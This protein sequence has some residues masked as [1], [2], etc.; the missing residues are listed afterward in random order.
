MTFSDYVLD[1]LLIA[2]VF[3]QI[4]ESRLDRRAILLP[5][6]IAAV[7]C[8]SYLHSIPT[9]GNDLVLIIS[10]TAVGVAL[11]TISAVATRVRTDG[12]RHA[13]VKASWLAAGVW[14]GSMG[15]RFAFSFWASHGGDAALG[16]F[17]V[18]HHI[19]GGDAWTA[20]LVLMAMGEVV[21]RTGLLF[22]RSQQ[23]VAMAPAAGQL[24]RA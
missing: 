22:L 20:A 3:R 15:F 12:G 9:S 2:I 13:L 10:F 7:V 4:R 8:N 17:S 14:V 19:T 23:A 18:A 21:T 5:L 6:G 11:G 1:I 16:R 24:V